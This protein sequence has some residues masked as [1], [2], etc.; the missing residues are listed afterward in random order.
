[1]AP[2]VLNPAWG[3]SHFLREGIWIATRWGGNGPD[4]STHDI[5]AAI[6]G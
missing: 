4:G 6:F 1:M 2:R 3:E 5:V